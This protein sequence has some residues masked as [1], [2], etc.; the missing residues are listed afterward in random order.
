MIWDFRQYRL[1]N[2]MALLPFP[3]THTFRVRS[4]QNVIGNV[5]T[6]LHTQTNVRPVF[7]VLY[8][9]Y[10]RI[11]KHY[12]QRWAHRRILVL[13]PLR[14]GWYTHLRRRAI[15]SHVLG[16]LRRELLIA[17]NRLVVVSKL[18][19]SE[20]DGIHNGFSFCS[21]LCSVPIQYLQIIFQRYGSSYTYV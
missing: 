21:M 5:P 18:W 14:R 9:Y 3:V 16:N 10:W 6:L 1:N 11:T 12:L 15:A 8:V 20:I 13:T 2:N 19:T 17:I 7:V 4:M